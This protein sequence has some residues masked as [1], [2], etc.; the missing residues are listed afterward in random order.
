M[1]RDVLVSVDGQAAR[2]ALREVSLPAARRAGGAVEVRR[3][4]AT[5]ALNLRA[6]LAQ[7][8]P[9]LYGYLSLVGL[10]FLVSGGFV[11]WRWP[12]IRGSNSRTPA[13]RRLHHAGLQPH[14]CG[15]PA[16]TIFWMDLAAGALVPAPRGPGVVALPAGRAGRALVR[17]C[18]YSGTAALLLLALWGVRGTEPSASRILPPPSRAWTG[19]R[20]CSWERRW[21]CR[22]SSWAWPT[23]VPARACSG[24][25]SAGCSGGFASGSPPSRSCTCF[26]GPW[27]PR[28]RPGRSS[29]PWSLFSSFPPF[30]TAALV[31]YRL[32]DLGLILRRGSE[33]TA[34]FARWPSMR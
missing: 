20:T 26:P 28:F 21:R 2:G 22:P 18:A 30:F 23:R 1:G 34:A 25:N 14:R 31:R 27:A 12:S 11:L 32:D 17:L 9:D 29:W 33:V 3:G 7:Q 8:A 15:R 10:A 16:W 19:C 4:G 5:L 24:G 13:W 6:D